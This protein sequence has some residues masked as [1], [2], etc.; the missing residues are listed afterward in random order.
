MADKKKPPKL[1]D[2]AQSKRFIEAAKAAAVAD[3]GL[4]SAEGEAAFERLVSKTLK[5]HPA[6][7]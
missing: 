5:P 6:K 1:E 7:G 2:E 4:N 3:G